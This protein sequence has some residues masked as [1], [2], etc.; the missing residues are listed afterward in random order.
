MTPEAATYLARG[1]D[2]YMEGVERFATMQMMGWPQLAQV[3]RSGQPAVPTDQESRGTFFATL[4]RCIFPMSFGGAMSAVATLNAGARARIKR[5]LDV[6]AGAAPWSIPFAHAIRGARVTVVDLPQ[7]TPVTREYTERFGVG[8]RYDSLEGDLREIDFGGGYDLVILGHIIHGEGRDA[9]RKLIERAAAALND[10][11]ILLIAELIPNDD[12]TGPEHPMLF[13][14]NMLVHVQ[15][16]DVFTM[17]DYREWLKT[18]G[19]KQVK[20]IRTPMAPSPLILAQ[21]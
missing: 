20:K 19:F 16:G 21:K 9:G 1:S 11:G 8:D 18:A 13:G 14:I 6:A 17:K 2:L 15:G 5:I 12:R 7:V 3:V 10:R 4:V